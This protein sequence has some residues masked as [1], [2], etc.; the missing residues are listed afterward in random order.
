MA[1]R[2]EG[3]QETLLIPLWCR[4][5]FTKI[6]N[7]VLVDSKAVDIV[8]RTQYDFSKI[9]QHLPYFLQIMNVVRTK[10]FDK[11]IGE[12]LVSHP[13]A[14][15][16]NLGAGLDT[17]FFRV[18]NGS[19]SWYDIDLP[20][21]ME[22][23][24]EI[25]PESERSH[26][27][28]E[29][30]FDMKWISRIG[31][32][33]DGLLFMSNGVLEYFDESIVKRF[34]TRLADHFPDSEIVFNTIRKNIISSFFTRRAMKKLGM[35][36]ATTKWGNSDASKIERWD[37]RI[38]I[39]ETYPVFSK[40]DKEGNFDRHMIEMMVRSDRWRAVNIVHMKFAKQ[41]H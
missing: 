41:G 14:T 27:I 30:I 32:T 10:M 33:T 16:V 3:V 2:L 24:R 8:G 19:L 38:S 13:H 20:D 25:M 29:S 31:A 11:T 18:D 36:S 7:A 26:Y 12:Y 39:I 15:I 5:K 34:L 6:G 9:D 28:A 21:V 23:R 1:I 22:I 17:T 37:N 4:A 35:A 40:I